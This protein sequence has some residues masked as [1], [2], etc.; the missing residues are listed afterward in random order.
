M[1]AVQL[2]EPVVEMG[3]EACSLR[4]LLNTRAVAYSTRETFCGLQYRLLDLPASLHAQIRT[5]PTVLAI[6]FHFLA[7][8][9]IYVILLIGE[10]IEQ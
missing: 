1:L 6:V 10:L 4:V 5:L 2:E 9:V 7:T 3:V 8:D